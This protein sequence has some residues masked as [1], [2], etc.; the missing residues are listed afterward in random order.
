MYFTFLFVFSAL[1]TINPLKSIQF[2]RYNTTFFGHFTVFIRTEYQLKY[3]SVLSNGQQHKASLFL[4]LFFCLSFLCSQLLHCGSYL[5]FTHVF[6]PST[7]EPLYHH[8]SG[9]LT[10]Q[11]S[12]ICLPVLGHKEC[13]ISLTVPQTL[14]FLSTSVSANLNTVIKIVLI[15]VMILD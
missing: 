12:S 2:S 10:A 11:F 7:L 13:P 6:C 3:Q 14:T 8:S 1:Y 5:S 15:D 4:C 9:K